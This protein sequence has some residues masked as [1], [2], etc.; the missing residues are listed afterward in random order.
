MDILPQWEL[1]LRIRH[2]PVSAEHK[3]ELLKLS[4]TEKQKAIRNEKL[5]SPLEPRQKKHTVQ[6]INLP[7][8]VDGHAFLNWHSGYF[9]FE[10]SGVNGTFTG[11]H[12][13][14]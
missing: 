3:T 2:A 9:E 1:R 7:N 8:A 5:L 12:D 6:H 10:L 14:A 4:N 11:K 13:L